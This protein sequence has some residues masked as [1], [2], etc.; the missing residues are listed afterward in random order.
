MMEP[1]GLMKGARSMCRLFFEVIPQ[2]GAGEEF[3]TVT[4]YL[5][6]C[7]LVGRRPIANPTQCQTIHCGMSMNKYRPVLRR[8]F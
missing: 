5:G 3:F 4:V 6:D 2:G 7:F 1:K 8:F